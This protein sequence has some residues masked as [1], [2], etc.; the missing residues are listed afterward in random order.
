MCHGPDGNGDKGSTKFRFGEIP[1]ISARPRTYF[2]RSVH[3]YESGQC[4]EYDIRNL[5]AGYES[6]TPKAEATHDYDPDR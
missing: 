4:P 2:I 5:A 3:D 1:R 6:R